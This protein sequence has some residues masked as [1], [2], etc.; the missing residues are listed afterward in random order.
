[1]AADYQVPAETGALQELIVSGRLLPGDRVWLEEG[2]HGELA[3]FGQVF[4]PPLHIEGL[5]GAQLNRINVCDTTGVTIEGVLVRAYEN[6]TLQQ[7]LGQLRKNKPRDVPLVDIRGSQQ[8]SLV[9]LDVATV[10]STEDWTKQD[11]IN[12]AQTGINAYG[13]GISVIDSTVKNVWH[14]LI[15]S[16]DGARVQNNTI[17]YFSGDGM[18]GLGNNS[19]YTGNHIHTCV[20]VDG[21][22][23]DGFQAW[24]RGPDRRPGKGIISNVRVEKNQIE[25]GSHKFSCR[26]QGIG[27]FDGIYENWVIADNVI[28]T[29]HWHGITVMGAR[30]V[31]V[32]RNIVVDAREGKPGPPW[33]SIT[34]HKD[35]R[36]P[37]NSVVH[38]NITQRD[39]SRSGGQWSV[40]R[41]GVRAYRNLRVADPERALSARP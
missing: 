40:P 36:V 28:V 18:R 24:T 33:I 39:L 8:I 19:Q 4:D 41:P 10:E 38:G 13:R 9:S 32:T 34:A 20:D 21:N 30:N 22:H 11:W 6:S 29:D 14:G 23:D 12:R 16:A 35:G 17:S 37:E 26:L 27:L 3:I 1:M 31:E 25:N 15:V 5:P 2:D 7:L